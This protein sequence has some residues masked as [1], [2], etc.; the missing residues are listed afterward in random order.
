MD[1]GRTVTCALDTYLVP[2]AADMPDVEPIMLESRGG[3]GPFGAKGIGEPASTSGA[4]AVT[5][6]VADA[7]GIRLTELPLTPERILTALKEREGSA[8]AAE[9]VRPPSGVAAETTA[10]SARRRAVLALCS[11]ARRGQPSCR[12]SAAVTRPIHGTGSSGASAATNETTATSSPP[13][14]STR[15][16]TA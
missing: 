8:A 12:P 3:M 5:N 15:L 13:S 6:A 1:Q 14:R 4:P 11:P 2:T 9:R 7:I 16:R 10:R